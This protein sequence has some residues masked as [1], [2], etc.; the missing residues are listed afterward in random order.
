MERYAVLASRLMAGRRELGID[1]VVVVGLE[2]ERSLCGPLLCVEGVVERVGATGISGLMTLIEHAALVVCNDSAAMH[3]AVAFGRPMVA[4][5]GPTDVGH[6][7][8]WGRPHD[9][10]S[11]RREGE[12]VRHRDVARASEIM[13]RIGVEEVVAACEKRL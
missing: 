12:R 4:L 1:A 2:S 5:F 11:H 10:I 3:M 13:R 7:G 9:V 6:A 8:P